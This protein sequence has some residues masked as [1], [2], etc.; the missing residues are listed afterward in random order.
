[1]KNIFLAL[2][3]IGATLVPQTSDAALAKV[4][5]LSCKWDVSDDQPVGA[6]TYKLLKI[7]KKNR[8]GRWTARYAVKVIPQNPTAEAIELKLESMESGDEDYIE[9]KVTNRNNFGIAGATI[10]NQ[11]KWGSLVSSDGF[12]N[13][14]CRK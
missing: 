4:F 1:M 12:T 11:F 5:T 3:L 13:F 10:Q 6:P 8:A 7:V 2:S 9:Y 14:V